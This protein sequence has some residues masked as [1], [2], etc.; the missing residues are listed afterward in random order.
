[1]FLLGVPISVH[2]TWHP[3]IALADMLTTISGSPG[4][5]ILPVPITL[6]RGHCR[7]QH[8]SSVRQFPLGYRIV[9]SLVW[10][11]LAA[12]RQQPSSSHCWSGSPHFPKLTGGV[13]WHQLEWVCLGRKGES[14]KRMFVF[15]FT[16]IIGSLLLYSWFDIRE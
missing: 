12:A 1:M 10:L 11:R 7:N 13:S 15:C 16:S 2:C 5:I 4:C 8:L 14:G 6:S 3:S 9:T